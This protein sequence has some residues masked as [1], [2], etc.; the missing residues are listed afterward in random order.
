VNADP[1][2]AKLA[3]L[4]GRKNPDGS[5]KYPVETVKNALA[6]FM[7]RAQIPASDLS[8]EM[9]QLLSEF[10]LKIGFVGAKAVPEQLPKL[11]DAFQKANP[12]PQEL[13]DE[14]A[15]ALTGSDTK[16]R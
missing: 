4:L 3:S 5:R 1:V 11:L 10:A 7:L 15:A 2:S 6:L 9:A 13:T 14:L 16:S 12:I 8:T